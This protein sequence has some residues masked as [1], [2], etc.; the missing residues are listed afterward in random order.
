MMD[1]TGKNVLVMGLG[2]NQGGLGVA[3]YVASKGASVIVTDLKSRDLLQ[4]TIAQIEQDE[5]LRGVELVLG[6]HRE[7]DVDWADYVVKNP[8]VPVESK[9]IQYAYEKDI[10]VITEF[11]IFFDAL[12]GREGVVTIGVTGTRGKSTTTAMVYHLLKNVQ[13]TPVYLVGNIRKSA[14]E[15]LDALPERA[16]ICIEMSSFQLELLKSSPDVAVFTSLFPD[17]LDRHH[18]MEAYLLAKSH[19]FLYQQPGGKLIVNDDNHYLHHHLATPLTTR[20]FR[21]SREHQNVEYSLGES[22]MFEDTE[23]MRVEDIAIPGEHN[24]MNAALAVATV[25][26][27]LG[28]EVDVAKISQAF[29][30]FT[31]LPGRLE[32]V[33]TVNGV[34]YIND[35]TSTMPDALITALKAF[36]DKSLVL[37][38]GGNDKGLDY[39]EIKSVQEKAN[40]RKVF[41]TPGSAKEKLLEVFGELVEEVES[42]QDAFRRST[43]EAEVGDVVLFS[44]TATSFGEFRHEFDRGD[45]FVEYVNSLM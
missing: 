11:E 1:F 2:L 27:V 24:E 8:A 43:E 34:S 19:I 13:D 41:L 16:F 40:I 7:K 37:I 14:L 12:K 35:T 26:Q 38:V 32:L 6:E 33:R 36:Q 30:S 18:T 20:V 23:L 4:E 39:S 5:L 25:H 28:Q 29:R 22:L 31:G 42:S 45:A 15:I 44:P 3:R 21:V 10:P 9:Y 17:H